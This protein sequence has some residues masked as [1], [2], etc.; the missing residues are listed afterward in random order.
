[1]KFTKTVF[2]ILFS[3]VAL[4]QLSGCRHLL[5]AVAF[6]TQQNPGKFDRVKLAQVVSKVRSMVPN[7]T[8]EMRLRLDESLH[9]ESIRQLESTEWFMRGDNVG[10]VWASKSAN[11]DLKVVI[12][13]K[14]LGHGGE[15]GFAYS[16]VP[17]MVTP[18]G[19]H[20]FFIDVPGRL[21]IV[22]PRMQINENWWKVLY[23][24]G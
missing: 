22:T 16:D 2:L 10:N 9:P 8:E 19:E 14:D 24:L 15:Y 3:F 17:L 18:F 4:T 13:T 5:Y 23:N 12:Q 11:G 6:K 21:N 20:W 1:M 7:G